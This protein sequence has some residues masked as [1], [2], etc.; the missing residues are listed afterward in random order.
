LLRLG[1]RT[2]E[3]DVVAAAHADASIDPSGDRSVFAFTRLYVD[4]ADLKQLVQEVD[5]L[6]DRFDRRSGDIEVS[7]MGSVIPLG[8]PEGRGAAR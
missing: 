2:V 6:F 4:E 7:F 1:F 3:A 5:S 8:G